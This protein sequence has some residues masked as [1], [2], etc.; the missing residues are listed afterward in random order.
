VKSLKKTIKKNY[1][2]FL[3]IHTNIPSYEKNNGGRKK[4]A[5]FVY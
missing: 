4:G 3:G 2:D 5:V 1:I